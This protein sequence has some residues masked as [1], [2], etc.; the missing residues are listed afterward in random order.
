MLKVV[1]T[2]QV[3]QASAADVPSG[4]LL[5]ELAREGARR[6]LAAALQAE[7][8]AYVDAFVEERDE[9][10]HRLV[11]RNGRAE[12]GRCSPPRARST[13][14]HRGSTTSASTKRPANAR[15]SPRRSC[16]RGAVARRRSPTCS[17]CCIC[18]ACPVETSFR[19]WS[20][21]SAPRRACRPRRSPGSPRRGRPSRKPSAAGICRRSTTCT[22]GPTASTL[23]SAWRSTSCACW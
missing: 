19:R 20:S 18:T 3:G 17:R 1:Q 12:S 2:T 6:M 5:D 23:T 14:T 11:V 10:G 22:C 8:D 4:S 21:S 13:C 9:D 7:A 15:G 16:P